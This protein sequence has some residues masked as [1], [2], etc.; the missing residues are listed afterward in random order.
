MK[1]YLLLF[2]LVFVSKVH[3]ACNFPTGDYINEMSNPSEI[4]LIDIK[5]PNSSKYAE[6]IFR[7][8]T[9]KSKII[10]N[11]L[12]KSF[13]ADI[14]IH[15]TFGIC[16]YSGK[17]R[18]S[19][20][21]KDHIKLKNGQPIRSLDVRLKDGNILN[22]VRFKLL[23]P[24]T[25]NG[26][27]EILATLILK[28]LGFIS[29]E[30]F[31]VK[32]SINGVKSVMIFQEKEAKELLE[33]NLRREG[34]IY[35]G[36]ESI[37]WTQKK[38]NTQKDIEFS[39]S[40]LVNDNWFKKGQSSQTITIHSFAKL[41]KNYL[42]SRYALVKDDGGG[43]RFKIFPNSLKD[44][45][46]LDF[47]T[48]LLAM[49]A[50]HGFY[51]HNRKYYFNAIESSLEPIYYDGMANFL[52]SLNL[53]TSLMDLIP[54][55]PSAELS[56]SILSLNKN[57]KLLDKFLIRIVNIK[58]ANKFFKTSLSNFQ[59]NFNNI[60]EVV[61]KQQITTPK[62]IQTNIPEDWY[63]EFQ[64]TK[65]LDHQILE[66]I[67]FDNGLYKGNFANG[68][69]IS[70]TSDEL[71]DIF[72]KNELANN[73]TV[74]IPS[75]KEKDSNKQIKFLRSE[76][77]FIKMSEG[78]RFKFEAEKKVL[79]FF[80]SN[81]SDWAL[82]YGGDY[83]NWKIIFEGLAPKSNKNKNSNQRFNQYGLTGCLTVYESLIDNL[84]LSVNGGD[85]E[86]SINII[87]SFG[88]NLSFIV[89]EAFSDAVDADFSKLSIKSLKIKDAQNDCIDLSGGE[90]NIDD[91]TLDGCQDKAISIGEKSI[92]NASQISVSNSNIALS[93]KDSSIAK[94][95]SL[96][97]KDVIICAEVK[98]KKQE[99][100]GAYL[101][102]KN[103]KC[104]VPNKIDLGS[105]F[106]TEES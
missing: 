50:K 81:P 53:D 42:K 16:E 69:S 38:S 26:L 60:I 89:K 30:T 48:V 78:M 51:L 80:Q 47:H 3:S 15:Y 41:Q 65:G 10:P 54:K 27:N 104:S 46:F 44:K 74:Y 64:K 55:M 97:A 23:I 84:S 18:Q 59:K 62:I 99:F 8:I 5:I 24:D 11:S 56:Q 9:S 70:L 39:L 61:S 32:T 40:R 102:I 29:P 63:Q 4:I 19:G 37:M 12:K 33:K 83:S 72:S 71:A 105:R 34:P 67:I 52:S 1:K 100:G 14:L 7:I 31:E 17:I 106:L 58:N 6:N 103:S 35:E 66:E 82:I 88:I 45:K 73:R 75:K 49:N 36:D 95:I 101:S 2:T 25:R 93:T 77:K 22:S 86:D 57:N 90:Y 91:A 21:L 68:K 76:D 98:N 96:D 28:E 13:K 92:L 94:I 87:N 20:D 43:W 79:Q 85:C